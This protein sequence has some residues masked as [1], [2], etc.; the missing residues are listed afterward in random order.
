MARKGPRTLGNKK[1]LQLNEPYQRPTERTATVAQ[2]LPPWPNGQG[3]GLLI[4]RLRVRVPQGVIFCAAWQS[5]TSALSSL[6]S[7][8]NPAACSVRARQHRI[9]CV[10]QV[11]VVSNHVYR[12]CLAS[13]WLLVQVIA[14]RQA[15]ANPGETQGRSSSEKCQSLFMQAESLCPSG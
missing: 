15:P 3:V 11:H 7:A 12:L 2:H 9:M 5:A 4:R 13:L 8:L 6:H 10:D 14:A 1:T